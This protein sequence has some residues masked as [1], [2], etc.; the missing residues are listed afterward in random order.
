M[1]ISAE[2]TKLVTDSTKPI[3]KKIAVSVQERETVNQLK[4]LGAILNEGG[5]KPKS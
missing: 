1:E 5:S 2:K 3:E 4:Y